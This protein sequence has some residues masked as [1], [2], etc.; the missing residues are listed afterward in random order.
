MKTLIRNIYNEITKQLIPDIIPE[1]PKM[2]FSNAKYYFG[3]YN[4]LTNT[5][6][7]SLYNLTYDNYDLDKFDILEIINTICHEIAHS[8]H[9]LHGEDHLELTQELTYRFLYLTDD[10]DYFQSIA[11]K[12]LDIAC[13]QN[14]NKYH[15]NSFIIKY[16]ILNKIYDRQFIELYKYELM[17]EV[18]V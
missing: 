12:Y 1:K 13:F 4:P 16:D 11:V 6:T 18:V 14:I 10:Y 17:S 8:I 9:Y 5:I 7:L 3:S 2:I 15:T